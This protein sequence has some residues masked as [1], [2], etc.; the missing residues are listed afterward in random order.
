MFVVTCISFTLTLC[1]GCIELLCQGCQTGHMLIKTD[2]LI[3][4]VI[5]SCETLC[6]NLCLEIN[7]TVQDEL[8]CNALSL[9]K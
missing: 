3:M 9:F 6:L 5:C 4:V 2:D 1:S 7:I 8:F